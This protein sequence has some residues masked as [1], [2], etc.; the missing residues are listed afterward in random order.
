MGLNTWICWLNGAAYA[1]NDLKVKSNVQMH[2]YVTGKCS[3]GKV[4]MLLLTSIFMK[5]YQ[6]SCIFFYLHFLLDSREN[7]NNNRL[8]L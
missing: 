4:D 1:Q 8:H 5:W 2:F 3:K 7:N 6:V